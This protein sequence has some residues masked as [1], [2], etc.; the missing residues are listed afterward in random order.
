[1]VRVGDHV[2]VRWP[3]LRRS[4]DGIVVQIRPESDQAP[5]GIYEV[6]YADG[7][8]EWHA[9]A[10][11]KRMTVRR[12]AFGPDQTRSAERAR[13]DRDT[14]NLHQQPRTAQEATTAPVVHRT[15]YSPTASAKPVHP[16]VTSF[17]NAATGDILSTLIDGTDEL[18]A[19]PEVPDMPK[20]AEPPTPTTISE[21]LASPL[22][23]HWLPAILREI[24]GHLRPTNR[25]PTYTYTAARSTAR[26]QLHVKW[27][28]VI[29]RHA[30]GS[31]DKFKAKAVLAGHWLKRGIDYT[32][33]YTGSSPWSDVLD[34]E[35]LAVSLPPCHP[36]PTASR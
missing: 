13:V 16:G 8:N 12:T 31:I 36:R 10:G 26:R 11:K 1:M 29:K 21:A 22:A 23:E 2:S 19:T 6:A 15:M 20:S 27:V 25:S 28:F 4:Y 17:V 18:P 30:D 9:A 5:G 7:S 35:S 3:R 32:E 34:L 33:S 24:G 14:A